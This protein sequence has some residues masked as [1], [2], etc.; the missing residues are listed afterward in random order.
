MA[1][2]AWV[3]PSR[4]TECAAPAATS[5]EAALRFANELARA[6]AGALGEALTG[7]ILHGS[8]TLDDY[9]PGRSDVDLLLV[10]DHPPSDA[11][12]VGLVEA[13]ASRR[14][15]APGPVDLRLVIRQVAASPTPATPLEAYLRLTPGSGVRWRS[16]GS[17]GERDLAPAP[18]RRRRRL[19]VGSD[20][21]PGDQ[22]AERGSDPAGHMSAAVGCCPAPTVGPPT[23]DGPVGPE[24]QCPTRWQDRRSTRW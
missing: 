7:V 17:P 3:P 10:V 15:E 4:S 20:G 19:V 5:A 23:A 2:S 21:K 1:H 6:C 12:L 9:V 8:L 24:R 22:A 13:M 11:R 18:R 16:A 14:A